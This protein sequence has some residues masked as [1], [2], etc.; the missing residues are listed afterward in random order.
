MN[1]VLLDTHTLV[2]QLED[3][4]QL[5]RQAAEQAKPQHKTGRNW[6]LP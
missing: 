3:N 4:P 2:W 5:G 1:P 6:C